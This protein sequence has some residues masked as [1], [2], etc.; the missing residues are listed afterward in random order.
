MWRLA[1]ISVLGV[2]LGSCGTLPKG[3]AGPVVPMSLVVE[4]VRCQI[5]RAFAPGNPDPGDMLSGKL[6]ATIT[7][8]SDSDYQVHPGFGRAAGKKDNLSWTAT[9]AGLSFTGDTKRH[10][11][12]EIKTTN[13]RELIALGPCP[14]AVATEGLG[15][16]TWLRHTKAGQP[17][18]DSGATVGKTTFR[19]TYKVLASTGGGLKLTFA[20]YTVS[21]EGNTATASN[22][23]VIDIRFGP[24]TGGAAPLQGLGLGR[25]GL[26]A[27][28]A[29]D[30]FSDLRADR[31][32]EEDD[33][34]VIKVP[35]GT[36]ITIGP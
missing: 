8:D 28:G 19:R 21:L 34:T 10:N 26:N 24:Q 18:L 15:V 17:G 36:P 29:L 25:L 20:E 33:E 27:Q 9:S 31:D 13:I 7:T 32:K 6:L 35:S 5:A 23:Y 30:D 12:A 1:V 16:E 22:T 3:G 11:E 14:N 4:A 2:G